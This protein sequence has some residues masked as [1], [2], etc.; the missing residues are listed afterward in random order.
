MIHPV[1]EQKDAW[2][3]LIQSVQIQYQYKIKWKLLEIKTWIIQYWS[4]RKVLISNYVQVKAKMSNLQLDNRINIRW[5]SIFYLIWVLPW[6]VQEILWQNRYALGWQ[7]LPKSQKYTLST[8]FS[9]SICLQGE[10]RICE[11]LGKYKVTSQ[12][13]N[14]STLKFLTF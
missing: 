14:I 3:F 8:T 12:K 13:V 4:N 10:P 2:L 6:K 7:G 5:I 1:K 9:H 11:Q